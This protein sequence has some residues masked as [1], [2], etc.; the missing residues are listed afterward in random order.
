MKYRDAKTL[1]IGDIITR[2]VDKSIW[3]IQ[4]IEI[5]GQYKKVFL[6]CINESN[7]KCSMYNV[8]IE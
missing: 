1:K 2:S 8:E 5:F 3:T 6:H 4:S 7:D